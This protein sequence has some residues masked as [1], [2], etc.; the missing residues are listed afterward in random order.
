MEPSPLLGIVTTLRLPAQGE[1]PL[2]SWVRWHLSVGF[3]HVRIL[4]HIELD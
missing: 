2:L 3:D 4:V 1:K